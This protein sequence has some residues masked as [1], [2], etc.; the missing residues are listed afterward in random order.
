MKTADK[1]LPFEE[2]EEIAKQNNT[3]RMRGVVCMSLKELRGYIEFSI[4][5]SSDSE[6]TCQQMEAIRDNI[7]AVEIPMTA[8]SHAKHVDFVRSVKEMNSR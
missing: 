1:F 8:E 4:K 6:L 3:F 2:H 7:R 5:T